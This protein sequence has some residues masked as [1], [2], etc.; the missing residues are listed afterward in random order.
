MDMTALPAEWAFNLAADRIPMARKAKWGRAAT[1]TYPGHVLSSSLTEIARMIEKYEAHLQ[2]KDDPDEQVM[3]EILAAAC[4]ATG[5][6]KEA[7]K[8]LNGQFDGEKCFRDALAVFK[9]H[10]SSGEA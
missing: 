3:R 9:K 10:A 7:D 2:P 5:A 8:Y 4:R 6:L 1:L